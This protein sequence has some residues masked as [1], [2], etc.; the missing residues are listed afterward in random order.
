MQ[1]YL[2]LFSF[3]VIMIIAN[4]F[5]F[6]KRKENKFTKGDEEMKN[7][8]NL[9]E[10]EKAVILARREYQRKWRENNKDKVKAHNERFF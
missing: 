2:L 4:D 7:L 6:V 9:S 3:C 5:T 1:K 10:E 8:T